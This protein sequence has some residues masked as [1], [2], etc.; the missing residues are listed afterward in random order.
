MSQRSP[1]PRS[2]AIACRISITSRAIMPASRS[3][4][5]AVPIAASTFFRNAGDAETTRARESA[6]C[7]QVHASVLW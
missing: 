1:S 4:R 7:S 3:C 5:S 6:M 2:S